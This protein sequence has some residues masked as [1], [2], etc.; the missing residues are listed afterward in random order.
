[1]ILHLATSDKLIIIMIVQIQDG[2]HENTLRVCEIATEWEICNKIKDIIHKETRILQ[3]LH[4]LSLSLSES[5]KICR[6]V[7]R[8]A[9]RGAHTNIIRAQLRE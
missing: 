6:L 3:N 7:E 9:M 2:G 4:H 1:M 5:R 8:A